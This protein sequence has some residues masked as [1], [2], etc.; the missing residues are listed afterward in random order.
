MKASRWT[1]T[2]CNFTVSPLQH[3]QGML[4]KVL[5]FCLFNYFLFLTG[6]E[7]YL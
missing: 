3:L 1:Q 5:F 6:K 2:E 7:Y 4:L